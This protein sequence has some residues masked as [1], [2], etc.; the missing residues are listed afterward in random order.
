VFLHSEAI[1]WRRKWAVV[2]VGTLIVMMSMWP[3]IIAV[4]ASGSDSPDAPE[5]APFAAFGLAMAPLVFVAVA[6]GSRNRHAAGVTVGAMG[7]FLVVAL[8]IGLIDTTTGLVAAY[9]AGGVIALRAE[10]EHR[11][12][13]RVIA[14]ALAAIYTVVVMSVVPALGIALAPL[15]PLTAVAIADVFMEYRAEQEAGEP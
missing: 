11:F 4:A 8:P 14:V 13:G 10:L 15:L 5:A 1:T 6:F 2:A 12:R 3:I 7:L 9:G